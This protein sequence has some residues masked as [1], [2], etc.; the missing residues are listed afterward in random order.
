VAKV[1][2]KPIVA[3]Q[4]DDTFVF[5]SWICITDDVLASPR[6]EVVA[7]FTDAS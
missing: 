3:F 6:P 2:I 5:G 1:I 4:K 7:R